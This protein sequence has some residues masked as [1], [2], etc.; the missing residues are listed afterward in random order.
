[1]CRVNPEHSITAVHAVH[2]WSCQVRGVHPL[3]VTSIPPAQVGVRMG[4]SSTNQANRRLR[5]KGA[6]IIVAFSAIACI[7][8]TKKARQKRFVLADG[9]VARD[10]WRTLQVRVLHAT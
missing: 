6:L 1:M 7:Q 9:H 10:I 5:P 2:S 3:R 8:K 4:R